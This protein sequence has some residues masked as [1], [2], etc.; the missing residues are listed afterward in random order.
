MVKMT[1]FA[2][3]ILIIVGQVCVL[4][5]QYQKKNI[6]FFKKALIKICKTTSHCLE[7]FL[8]FEKV[9]RNDSETFVCSFRKII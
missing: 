8:S 3:H 1:L 7:F 4:L 5:K 2:I 9:D 6:Y